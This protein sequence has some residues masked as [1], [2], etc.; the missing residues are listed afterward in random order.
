MGFISL[1]PESIYTQQV[2]KNLDG[3]PAAD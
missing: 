2:Q 1:Y 3:M